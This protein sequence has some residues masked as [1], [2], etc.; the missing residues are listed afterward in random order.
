MEDPA[1]SARQWRQD[2]LIDGGC[3]GRGV[4]RVQLEPRK[5]NK[6]TAAL[7]PAA[8]ATAA[9][10]KPA[11]MSP[12][13]FGVCTVTEPGGATARWFGS[14]ITPAGAVEVGPLRSPDGALT[15]GASVLLDDVSGGALLSR[16]VD[17]TSPAD[18]PD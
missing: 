15:G 17:D 5:K 11:E 14:V 18:D 10:I 6:S 13:L 2:Q 1:R 16:L 12:F 3:G 9:A 4:R 7:T 8:V